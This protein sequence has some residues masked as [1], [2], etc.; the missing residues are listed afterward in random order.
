MG[1]ESLRK[2]I[3]MTICFVFRYLY[4]LICRDFPRIVTM[5]RKDVSGQVVVITGGAMGIGKGLSVKFANELK[6]KVCILDINDQMGKETRDEILAAGGEAYFYSCNVADPES[7]RMCAQQI[8]SNPHLGTVDI[9]VCN[10]AVLRMGEFTEMSDND[11]KVNNDVNILGYI[12]TIRAFIRKMMDN[13]K[14][15]I[16]CVGSICSHYG[17]QFGTA[18]CTAKFAIRG[19]MEAL[20]CEL[21]EKQKNGIATTMIYPY[22]TQTTLV[23]ENMKEPFSTHLDVVPLDKCVEEMTDAIL[24]ERMYYFIPWHL[25]FFCTFAKCLTTKSIL[26]YARR[27]FNFRYE[28]IKRQTA[29]SG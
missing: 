11:F 14:G 5:K 13:N 19:L 9:L 7:V 6:A 25:T 17:E 29:Q 22:F 16:V 18:Y 28:P 10:A 2:R 4:C 26:P 21:L 1:R 3:T 23:T 15:Q 8:Y 27:F 24:K 12:Y 20:Q